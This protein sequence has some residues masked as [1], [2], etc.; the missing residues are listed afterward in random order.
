MTKIINNLIDVMD[1]IIFNRPTNNNLL[2]RSIT[3][4]I[5][6]FLFAIAIAHWYL[7]MNKGKIPYN[8][9]DWWAVSSEYTIIKEGLMTKND[10][11]SYDGKQG[12]LWDK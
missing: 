11:L 10:P 6:V 3:Y 4:I 7:F 9:F 1:K 2:L 8:S 12:L 5:I